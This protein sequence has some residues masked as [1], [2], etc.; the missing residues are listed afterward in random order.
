VLTLVDGE[1]LLADGMEEA[2]KGTKGIE[3]KLKIYELS[4]TRYERMRLRKC[5]SFGIW[6]ILGRRIT[7]REELGLWMEKDIRG[8]NRR[9]SRAYK[10]QNQTQFKITQAFRLSFPFFRFS[11]FGADVL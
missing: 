11:Y 3:K 10:R 5:E 2:I 1:M 6:R 9:H 7:G 8:W 4:K